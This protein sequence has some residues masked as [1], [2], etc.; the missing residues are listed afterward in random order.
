MPQFF[1]TDETNTSYTSRVFSSKALR[2]ADAHTYYSV[3]SGTASG[4]ISTAAGILHSV[5]F[6]ASA[7]GSKFW[8][9]DVSGGG[10]AG[11]IGNSASAIARFEGGTA[12]R[13]IIFDAI[14]NG[15]LTYR[16]SA[17]V[18]DGITVVYSVAG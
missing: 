13:Q 15:G 14:F 7:A 8:L 16:L 18:Q 10:S 17:A 3:P 1:L 12:N 6:G 5:I 4:A 11:D 9:F 2:V